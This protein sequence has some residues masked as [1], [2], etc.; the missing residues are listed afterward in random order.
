MFALPSGEELHGGRAG[1]SSGGG[2]AAAAGTLNRGNEI[3]IHHIPR[4]LRIVVHVS[5]PF[6]LYTRK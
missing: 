6:R 4:I 2:G 1:S 5:F 3:F